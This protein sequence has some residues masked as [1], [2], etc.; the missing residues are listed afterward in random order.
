M[1]TGIFCVF[2]QSVRYI[3]IPP[4]LRPAPPFP[5]KHKNMYRALAPGVIIF[6]RRAVKRIGDRIPIRS[7]SC[8]VTSGEVIL[9]QRAQ[10]LVPV[11]FCPGVLLGLCF[12]FNTAH[13]TRKF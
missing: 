3:T 10:A 13:P 2:R 9:S 1:S 8:E 7:A 5:V 11:A 4:A 12:E 6:Y